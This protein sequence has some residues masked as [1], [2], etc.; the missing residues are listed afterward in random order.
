MCP[1]N[2]L[3]NEQI[4][5][6]V[7]YYYKLYSLP[8]GQESNRELRFCLVHILRSYPESMSDPIA[9]LRDFLVDYKRWSRDWLYTGDLEAD[10]LR[11]LGEIQKAAKQN[12]LGI[13]IDFHT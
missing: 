8:G 6:L 3:S 11:L 9:S 2:Y 1:P 5:F 13:E 7:P 4:S 10:L 12:P